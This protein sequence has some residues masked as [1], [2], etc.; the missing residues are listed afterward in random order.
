MT[1]TSVA[2]QIDD[3]VFRLNSDSIID[4]QL[5]HKQD[6]LWIV[7]VDVENR[8]LHHL[9]NVGAVLGGTRVVTVAES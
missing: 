6:R 1:A 5:S 3:N 9:G 8:R 2:N 4:G 7:G